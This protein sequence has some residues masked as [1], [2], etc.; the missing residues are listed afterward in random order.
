[1]E[2]FV[3]FVESIFTSNEGLVTSKVRSAT[4]KAVFV[5][6]WNDLVCVWVCVICVYVNHWKTFFQRIAKGQPLPETLPLPLLFNYAQNQRT[7]FINTWP[8]P[9][10]LQSPK[11]IPFFMADQGE[12]SSSLWKDSLLLRQY[13]LPPGQ[14]PL[15][16]QDYPLPQRG[17]SFAQWTDKARFIT[18]EAKIFDLSRKIRYLKGKNRYFI[19]WIRY[20]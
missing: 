17:D 13:P 5:I 4:P 8:L 2:I 12:H 16:Q 19:G 7:S 3:T 14:D 9:K 18:S 10:T 20:I 11:K 15:P 6:S 1:M